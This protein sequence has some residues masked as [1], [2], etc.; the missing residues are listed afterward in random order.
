MKKGILSFLVIFSLL[1]CFTFNS[2][3]DS[4][5]LPNNQTLDTSNLSDQDILNAIRLARK[6]SG[7][8]SVSDVVNGMDPNKIDDWRKLITGTIK[9][10]CNDLS[11][12]VN[13]FV[14]TPV[15]LGIAALIVYK[16]AGKDLL[17]NALDIVI[18]IP[19]WFIFTG[20]VLFFGWYFFSNITVYDVSYNDTGKKIKSGGKRIP[21]Y[22]WIENA[23]KETNREPMA[24]FLIVFEIM[25]T[26]LA[27]M[28]VLI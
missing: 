6:S 3:A 16:V 28:I 22:A 21:R 1:I 10:V 25:F 5:T 8:T 17:D 13:E 27:L 24:I 11:I 12:T 4:I 20:L 9:D 18:M 7:N 23:K 14:K 19:L 15:G 2:Y 26:I